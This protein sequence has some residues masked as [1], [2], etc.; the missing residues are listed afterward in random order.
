MSNDQSLLLLENQILN[1]KACEKRI[2]FDKDL[3]C[4]TTMQAFLDLLEYL[5]SMSES[6]NAPSIADDLTKLFS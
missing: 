6:Q 3:G 4:M 5:L 1:L 2:S